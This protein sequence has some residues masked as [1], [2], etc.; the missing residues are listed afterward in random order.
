[1]IIIFLL[2]VYVF[3]EAF[4]VTPRIELEQ[5]ASVREAKEKSLMLK[6]EEKTIV[7]NPDGV[8]FI[9]K[10]SVDTFIEVEEEFKIVRKNSLELKSKLWDYIYETS[11]IEEKN[12]MNHLLSLVENYIK[13]S[14]EVIYNLMESIKNYNGIIHSIEHND[15]A[16]FDFYSKDVKKLDA[17][18]EKILADNLFHEKAKKEYA[19]LIF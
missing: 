16:L 15:Q 2:S 13:S 19:E 18:R 12:Q 9:L 5:N 7:E 3:Y 4:V 11:S 17:E 1:M 8:V 14:D 10:Q 6:E